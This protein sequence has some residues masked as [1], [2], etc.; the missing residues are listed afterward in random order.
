[1]EDDRFTANAETMKIFHSVEDC[2]KFNKDLTIHWAKMNGFDVIH[3]KEGS[4]L[5]VM[6]GTDQYFEVF[7]DGSWEAFGMKPEGER[8]AGSSAIMLQIYLKVPEEY[9]GIM[10]S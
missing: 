9:Q 10:K 2:N 3:E 1:M 6:H 4:T 8:I 7:N 5:C